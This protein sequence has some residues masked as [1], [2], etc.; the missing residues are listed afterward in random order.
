MYQQQPPLTLLESFLQ[1]QQAKTSNSNL[2]AMNY[3]SSQQ[4]HPF[5]SSHIPQPTSQNQFSSVLSTLLQNNRMVQ[6]RC[7]PA[8]LSQ[9][10]PPLMN[11]PSSTIEN[12]HHHQQMIIPNHQLSLIT[13][14]NNLCHEKSAQPAS[15]TTPPPLDSNSMRLFEN[16]HQPRQWEDHHEAS[17]ITMTDFGCSHH[18]HPSATT[19]TPNSSIMNPPPPQSMNNTSYNHS[20]NHTL[21]AG[22]D[23]STSLLKLL[24]SLLKQQQTQPTTTL[25]SLLNN[26]FMNP[27]PHQPPSMDLFSQASVSSLYQQPLGENNHSN[28]D[29][30]FNNFHNNSNSYCHSQ[31]VLSG[32][33][34][35]SS[36]SSPPTIFQED[37]LDDII[38]YMDPNVD[39]H[40]KFSF[41]VVE[42]ETKTMPPSSS[43][44]TLNTINS[45]VSLTASSGVKSQLQTTTDS[46]IL[47]NLKTTS[48]VNSAYHT[49]TAAW[50]TR[51]SSKET[52]TTM[53]SG[54]NHPV[55]TE[56]ATKTK[57]ASSSR[58][59]KST[60]TG[61]GR[62]GDTS[63]RYLAESASKEVSPTFE[64]FI[65]TNHDNDDNNATILKASSMDDENGCE[66][67][68][69]PQERCLCSLLSKSVLPREELSNIFK[70][71]NSTT[72]R[73][74]ISKWLFTKFDAK[75]PNH[76]PASVDSSE[77]SM[78]DMT[79]SSC[80]EVEC[81]PM[82]FTINK[83][84]KPTRLSVFV[85]DTIKFK[86]Q[87]FD[88]ENAKIFEGDNII[89]DSS[90]FNTNIMYLFIDNYTAEM[91]SAHY[92]TGLTPPKNGG[93]LDTSESAAP[94]DICMDLLSKHSI[95]QY[96]ERLSMR[97]EQQQTK[98]SSA[99]RG[100]TFEIG[101]SIRRDHHY[102][103]KLPPIKEISSS[104]GFGNTSPNSAL[105]KKISFVQ[106]IE[107]D[108]QRPVIRSEPFWCR[109]KSRAEME[110]KQNREA[111]QRKSGKS[112]IL[113]SQ[114]N[115]EDESELPCDK[116]HHQEKKRRQK[117]SNTHKKK[118]KVKIEF[119]ND[120]D[121]EEQE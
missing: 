95:V 117:S 108:T 23:P 92:L 29:L 89:S 49:Y 20:L 31:P 79:S 105:N 32:F 76:M 60:G 7:P 67:F 104:F 91:R 121:D 15:F 46:S 113:L 80:I 111:L 13:V 61:G 118:K 43:S 106:I 41:V 1:Q 73:S 68:L 107:T 52:T 48:G 12:H 11:M 6:Q 28:L 19:T 53:E 119:I 26:A 114:Q 25:S 69:T 64:Y 24:D 81:V 103:V 9:Q 3:N 47:N 45:V 40:E 21:F 96:S 57:R 65:H 50:P 51:D 8:M 84:S 16:N 86:I 2:T 30:S 17:S 77:F 71:P 39:V 63:G 14:L 56:P 27:S 62:N 88:I 36:R 116:E 94:P 97:E 109:S 34:R 110:K 75:L 4:H 87:T 102:K 38:G 33:S 18:N 10:Q 22:E 42:P 70:G 44:N 115:E 120:D 85:N 93:V 101:I 72:V 55:D 98:S 83:G 58:K 74:I 82:G 35:E 66:I 90:I 100:S 78:H 54:Q 112:S 37:H 99:H 5:A 59:K